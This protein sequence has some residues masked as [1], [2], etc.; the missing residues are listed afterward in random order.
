M[1]SRRRLCW[2]YKM[3][4]DLKVSFLLC[5]PQKTQAP[6]GAPRARGPTLPHWSPAGGRH[7]RGSCGREGGA[8]SPR[9]PGARAPAPGQNARDSLRFIKSL[10]APRG[11]HRRFP[12]EDTR[13]LAQ[14]PQ[15]KSEQ[16]QTNP[17]TELS[18][19][20][21]PSLRGSVPHPAR[22][23]RSPADTPRLRPHVRFHS[24]RN[25]A[26]PSRRRGRG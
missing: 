17:G 21:T 16:E 19:P 6:R 12:P 22:P 10:S 26:P 24:P 4:W 3:S 7:G 2:F 1:A 15:W 23:P 18:G 14:V 20:V 13:F 11:G 5:H 25:P 9:D 8:G